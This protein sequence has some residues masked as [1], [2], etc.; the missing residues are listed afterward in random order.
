[1]SGTMQPCGMF[2]PYL[3]HYLRIGPGLVRWILHLTSGSVC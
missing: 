1:M 2:L 3:V